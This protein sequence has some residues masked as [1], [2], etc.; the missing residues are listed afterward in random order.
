MGIDSI[1]G[2]TAAGSEMYSVAAPGKPDVSCESRIKTDDTFKSSGPDS[3]KLDENQ[4]KKMRELLTGEK[5]GSN[6]L[7][8]F[9][10]DKS[11][12]PAPT[13]DNDGNIYVVSTD[14]SINSHVYSIDSSGNM[15]WKQTFQTLSPSS[16]EIGPDGKTVYVS[17]MNGELYALDREGEKKMVSGNKGICTSSPALAKDGTAYV[18]ATGN[19]YAFDPEGGEKWMFPTNTMSNRHPLVVDNDGSIYL[20]SGNCDSLK[21]VNPRGKL[22]WELSF[23]FGQKSIRDFA[24]KDN[25]IYSLVHRKSNEPGLYLSSHTKHPSFT[26]LLKEKKPDKNWELNL[27][28]MDS[29]AFLA[30]GGPDNSIYVASGNGNLCAV[31]QEGNV[32]WNYRID[33]SFNGRP[34]FDNEGNIYVT[35]KNSSGTFSLNVFDR[36][37]KKK[38]GCDIE[39]KLSSSMKV[40][41]VF[42]EKDI[43]SHVKVT[44]GGTVLISTAR[45]SVIA[46]KENNIKNMIKEK[47]SGDDVSQGNVENEKIVIE[48]DMVIIGGVSLTVKKG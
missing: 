24:V 18:F 23:L 14:D 31:D 26:K 41:P 10:T 16:P 38:W 36:E 9:K 48:D 1:K 46:L 25:R 28:G 45:G 2:F 11:L 29:S 12:V 39:E 30:V 5:T 47:L 19:L 6:L 43:D 13:V 32:K 17:G 35:G 20:F 42:A 44:P 21:S 3:G 34:A 7:W 8:S 40:F 22:N 37:G 15:K 27:K 33:G 4:M